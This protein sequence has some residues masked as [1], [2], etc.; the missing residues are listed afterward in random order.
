MEFNHAPSDGPDFAKF[1]EYLAKQFGKDMQAT[2][3]ARDE[4][5]KRQGALSA[6]EATIQAK[7]A[8]DAY[9]ETTKQSCDKLTAEANELN[10]KAKEVTAVLDNREKVLD[11]RE[12]AD[13]VAQ[14]NRKKALDI[15]DAQ[16]VAERAILNKR[17]AELEEK[18]AAL[19]AG[20]ASLAARVKAFQDKV[21]LLTA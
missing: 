3:A 11:T 19:L 20:E 5:A 14:A 2:L 4:L 15:R 18:A 12:K 17:A 9:Y 16:L 1:V 8:A 21:A 6:V 7:A 10:A 13:G